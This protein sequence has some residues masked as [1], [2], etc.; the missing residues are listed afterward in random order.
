MARSERKYK[1]SLTLGGL[2]L[3]LEAHEQ[4]FGEVKKL[5]ALGGYSV[6]TF[7]DGNFP[8]LS[9]LALLPLIGGSAPPAPGS[10]IHLFN[11]EATI[12]GV[13]TNVAVYRT[14]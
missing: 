11:G 7:D 4:L 2:E 8:A 6:A 5:E 9:S 12:L 1:G 10:S 3:A 13:V 14:D